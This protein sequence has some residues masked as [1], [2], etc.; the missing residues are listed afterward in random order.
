MNAQHS[1]PR[2]NQLLSI[3]VVVLICLFVVWPFVGYSREKP[4]PKSRLGF[5]IQA[6]LDQDEAVIKAATKWFKEA[7]KDAGRKTELQKL[8]EEGMAPPVPPVENEPRY[9]WVEIAPVE[10][11]TLHLDHKAEKDENYTR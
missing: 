5:H 7:A 4:Q 11:S 10:L 3:S 1:S 8:A 6:Q 9:A 2:Q